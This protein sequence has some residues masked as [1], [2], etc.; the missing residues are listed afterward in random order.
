MADV[1]VY[2][3]HDGV[4]VCC[5]CVACT[6]WTVLARA[7]VVLLVLVFTLEARAASTV[8]GSAPVTQFLQQVRFVSVKAEHP[9]PSIT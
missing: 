1:L 5:I 2:P 7:A 8:A 6:Y 3:T 9:L 4:L